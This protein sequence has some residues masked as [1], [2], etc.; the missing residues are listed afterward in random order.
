VNNLFSKPAEYLLPVIAA[1]SLEIFEKSLEE[2]EHGSDHVR[3]VLYRL[4]VVPPLIFSV[5]QYFSWRSYTLTPAKTRQLR[6]ELTRSEL[7]LTEL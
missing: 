5:L 3:Q 1:S 6:D 4:L 7:P 2:S